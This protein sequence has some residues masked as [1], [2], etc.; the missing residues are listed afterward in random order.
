MSNQPIKSLRQFNEKAGLSSFTDREL[1]YAKLSAGSL[2]GLD[3]TSNS[4]GSFKHAKPTYDSRGNITSFSLPTTFPGVTS[5]GKPT[6]ATIDYILKNLGDNEKNIA[7]GSSISDPSRKEI[8]LPNG[9]KMS[10]SEVDAIVRSKHDL[11]FYEKPSS[12]EVWKNPTDFRN[13]ESR[14]YINN[15]SDA[16]KLIRVCNEISREKQ[17]LIN[18]GRLIKTEEEVKNEAG[19][20]V[21]TAEVY[22]WQAGEQL[23]GQAYLESEKIFAAMDEIGIG[24]NSE[25][26]DPVRANLIGAEFDQMIS[27]YLTRDPKD[28]SR[29]DSKGKIAGADTLDFTKMAIPTGEKNSDGSWLYVGK[30]I[31]GYAKKGGQGVIVSAVTAASISSLIANKFPQLTSTSGFRVF[32]LFAHKLHHAEE[33]IAGSQL[34]GESLPLRNKLIWVKS[35]YGAI[36]MVQ[37][38]ETIY[39]NPITPWAIH[40]L[41]HYGAKVAARLFPSLFAAAGSGG[42]ATALELVWIF[43]EWGYNIY[44]EYWGEPERKKIEAEEKKK[45][46]EQEAIRKKCL[47]ARYVQSGGLACIK[48]EPILKY[49]I[50]TGESELITPLELNSTTKLPIGVERNSDGTIKY[51][52]EKGFLVPKYIY[53][54]SQKPVPPGKREGTGGPGDRPTDVGRNF[55]GPPDKSNQNPLG[56]TLITQTYTNPVTGQEEKIAFAIVS[57]NQSKEN[58]YNS[59]IVAN[60]IGA[61][62]ADYMQNLMVVRTTSNPDGGTIASTNAGPIYSAA[63]P[64]PQLSNISTA[65]VASSA[66]AELEAIRK[67]DRSVQAKDKAWQSLLWAGGSTDGGGNGVNGGGSVPP[68]G[69]PQDSGPETMGS[70]EPMITKGTFML[71]MGFDIL[72][73]VN[74]V[75]TIISKSNRPTIQYGSGGM[76]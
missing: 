18:S 54:P 20:T 48:C 70:P 35:L 13:Q 41:I 45:K 72:Y 50:L 64:A 61:K 55:Y 10:F 37:G 27:G 32:D 16:R 66:L 8:T 58:E 7:G 49:N 65:A 9:E 67:R 15:N 23:E 34:G 68:S 44:D 39:N 57:H 76:G 69:T 6:E 38:K 24:P 4:I 46:L 22:I 3:V 5:D 40:A 2:T 53:P 52:P 1:R 71:D 36:A 28:G 62:N 60:F 26:V 31:L 19:Q 42:A 75:G 63:S 12:G 74:G 29:I 73:V 59:Y 14:D 17:K 11:A 21:G 56:E 30:N 47:I 43:S 51:D 33:A 25:K